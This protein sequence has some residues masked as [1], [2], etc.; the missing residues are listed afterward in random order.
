MSQGELIG[1]QGKRLVSI[2]IPQ[3]DIPRFRYGAKQA[4]G[5]GQGEGEVGDTIGQGDPQAGQGQAGSEPGEHILE[6]DVTLDELAK[7]M[8][9]ELQLPNIKPKSAV[10]RTT[11]PLGWSKPYWISRCRR[12]F[13]NSDC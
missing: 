3:I 10:V 8:A 5:V 13:N 7:I 11:G 4:G 2:P 12:F 9:E 6:V 1:R